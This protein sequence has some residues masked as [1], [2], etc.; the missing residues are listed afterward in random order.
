MNNIKVEITKLISYYFGEQTGSM[1]QEYYDD[2]DDEFALELFNEVL[3]AY[4]GKQKAYTIS[5]SLADK[6]HVELRGIIN[7]K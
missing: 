7:E 4:I 6:Y 3:G 1:Y 2:K 5:K